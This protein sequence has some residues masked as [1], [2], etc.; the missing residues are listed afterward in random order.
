MAKCDGRSST[1]VT[2]AELLMKRGD[3]GDA[4]HKFNAHLPTPKRRHRSARHNVLGVRLD[5]VADDVT[6]QLKL[7]VKSAAGQN[8]SQ[9]ESDV[10]RTG[11][12]A[13]FNK[14]QSAQDKLHIQPGD[15]ITAVN[16]SSDCANM[17][18][19][20]HPKPN[21][22]ALKV[23]LSIE[24]DRPGVLVPQLPS[25][26]A[27]PSRPL[28][29]PAK[30]LLDGRSKRRPSLPVLPTKCEDHKQSLSECS[31][32]CSSSRCSLAISECSTRSSSRC[33]SRASTPR[34]WT[35]PL[36]ESPVAFMSRIRS[37]DIKF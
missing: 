15:K 28:S 4:V 24:R 34:N 29:G 13:Q 30:L 37:I 33:S 20:L 6:Q 32:R 23:T 1:P 27:R 19:Q 3:F 31:T 9:V 36:Q 2:Q 18:E 8:W 22:E 7:E 5:K 26:L 35:N 11:L 25:P 17:L 14:L 21:D 16:H 10:V 12:V